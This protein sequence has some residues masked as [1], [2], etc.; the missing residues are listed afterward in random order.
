MFV[1]FS[2]TC[3]RKN[4]T[5]CFILYN[6]DDLYTSVADPDLFIRRGPQ[7]LAGGGGAGPSSPPP[8]FATAHVH[9]LCITLFNY[10]LQRC[11]EIVQ[12]VTLLQRKVITIILLPINNKIKIFFLSFCRPTSHVVADFGCGEAVIAQTVTNKV[13][14]FDLVAKNKF[15][16][17][18]N[19]A[20]VGLSNT[21][22]II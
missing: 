13:H 5:L 12:Q 16:T 9:V 20:K 21:K 1:L 8:K 14:S 7:T 22:N 15:V 6:T 17:A 4:C 10:L 11:R 19:M 18:C 3:G 2:S